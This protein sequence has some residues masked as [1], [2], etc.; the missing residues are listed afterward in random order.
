MQRKAKVL[1]VDD[2]IAFAESM[3]DILIDNGYEAQFV[4]SGETALERL[5]MRILIWSSWIYAYRQ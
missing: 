2:E 3:T 1:V 4:N 5:R